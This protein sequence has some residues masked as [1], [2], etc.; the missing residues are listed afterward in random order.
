MNFI[1]IRSS[2]IGTYIDNK[3]VY[4]HKQN[5]RQHKTASLAH[6]IYGCDSGGGHRRR[7]D[8]GGGGGGH[9]TLGD[10]NDVA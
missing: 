9:Y 5:T 1:F 4:S 8:D 7:R 2:S 3:C 10:P 6:I